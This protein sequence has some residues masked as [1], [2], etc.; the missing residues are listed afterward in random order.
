MVVVFGGFDEVALVDG[1]QLFIRAF[2]W[3]GGRGDM[4]EVHEDTFYTPFSA[5]W[6]STVGGY[7]RLFRSLRITVFTTLKCTFL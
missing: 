7:Y 3:K 4:G 1:V 5:F 6:L 2:C